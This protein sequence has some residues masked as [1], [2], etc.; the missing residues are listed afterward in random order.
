[1][2]CFS[3]RLANA[4]VGNPRDAATLEVT[5]AGPAVRFDDA[6]MF[7]VTGARFDLQLDGEVVPCQ[8]AALANAGA[9]LT[10]GDRRGGARAYLAIA[11][12]LDVPPVLGSRATHLPTAMGGWHG[13]AL[14]RGD[15]LPL[16]DA[17]EHT[18]SA[19]SAPARRRHTAVADSL[20]RVFGEPSTSAGSAGA[21]RVRVLPGPHADR[22]RAEALDA[23]VSAPYRLGVDS[24]RMAFH[25]EGPGL[26]HR[27]V[28]DI[29]S[30]AT[31]MGA[32]QV[33]GSGRPLLLM[34]DRQTTGGYAQI[35]TVI[36]ADLSAAAQAA[37]ADHV[38]FEVCT[39]ADA[40]AAL[41]ERE[42]G[43]LAVGR[44][45]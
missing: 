22:F 31:P 21:I 43:L 34:A 3:H 35:A 9:T 8:Q 39:E 20:D 2:D 27:T 10:F 42:R 23:L 13:R 33:P 4:L 5:M 18:A 19:G 7:A 15:V 41:V 14:R 32:L 36:S 30:D 16:G 29:I 1:M 45:V 6:R 40:L 37:P 25:L 28:A 38:R 17:N 26:L 24:N 11:G 12:G 44:S